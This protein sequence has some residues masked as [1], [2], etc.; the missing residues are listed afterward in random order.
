MLVH[1]I[2]LFN[3]CNKSIYNYE[4]IRCGYTTSVVLYRILCGIIQNSSNL[5]SFLNPNLH[6]DFP[7]FHHLC[8]SSFLSSNFSQHCICDIISPF[9]YFYNTLFLSPHYSALCSANL[10]FSLV[11]RSGVS[12]HY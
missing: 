1:N 5:S 6:L 3:L 10:Y 2:Y 11:I 9:W 12:K 4:Y 7:N 8:L